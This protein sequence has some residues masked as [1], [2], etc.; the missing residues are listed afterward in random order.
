M[1]SVHLHCEGN[2]GLSAVFIHSAKESAVSAEVKPG[3]VSESS[4]Q[5]ANITC[6]DSVQ[7]KP[8]GFYSLRLFPP[9]KKSSVSVENNMI[10]KS[11]VFLWQ[12]DLYFSSRGRETLIVEPESANWVI[13]NERF[14]SLFELMKKPF[15][16]FEL[17]ENPYTSVE[18]TYQF[19]RYLLNRNIIRRRDWPCIFRPV[20]PSPLLY[21]SFLSIH[22]T[23]SCNFGCKYCYGD[24][25]SSGKKMKKETVIKIIDRIYE[26]LTRQ[27]ITIEFHGGEPLLVMDVVQAASERIK[28][29]WGKKTDRRC[30][31]LLQ[32]NASLINEETIDFFRKYDISV[33]V[34][35]DGSARTHDRSRTYRDGRGTHADTLRG[36]RFLKQHNITGG[37]L[38]VVEDPRDYI[39]ITSYIFSLGYFG[40]RLNHLVC[41]GRGELDLSSARERGNNFAREFLG[42]VDYLDAYAREHRDIRLDIWPVNIM[43]F[44]LVSPHRPFMCMRSPCG[45]GSHGLGF[46]YSGNVYPCEQL[47][48]FQEL[49]IGN[50]NDGKGILEMLDES[51]V[52]KDIRSRTVENI[53][54]CRTC[55]FRNFCG[56]GCTAE[57]YSISKDLIMEDAHCAFYEK[58]FEN[59]MWELHRKGDL[60]HLMGQF[61]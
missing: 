53:K 22:V 27:D 50:V 30:R 33:G 28:K 7:S 24:A 9:E 41:Q 2:T 34:S 35:M 20:M 11:D 48:G 5:S 14:F 52:I 25:P 42:L 29:L 1:L 8:G 56:A 13:L 15:P 3:A 18:E 17:C 43:L 26:E 36:L 4:K 45:A 32:T 60:S 46:D 23:E 47:A 44:H 61:R 40:F 55:A 12:N 6:R 59:L 54:K 57:A 16:L 51:Q 10:E 19:V 58:T 31:I 39:E 37:V 49:S 21:P 38:A